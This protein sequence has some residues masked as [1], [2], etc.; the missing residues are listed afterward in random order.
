MTFQIP[1][2]AGAGAASEIGLH[3]LRNASGSVLAGTVIFD[4]NYR[5]GGGRAD[6]GDGYRWQM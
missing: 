3:T 2:F 6:H 5:P 1:G 4:V